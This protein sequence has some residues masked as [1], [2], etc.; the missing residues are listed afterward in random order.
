MTENIQDLPV[1]EQKSND[2]DYNFAQMRNQLAQERAAKQAAEAR[3]S[4]LERMTQNSR[5]YQEEDDDSEPYVDHKK[6]NK[7]FSSFEKEMEK[8]IDAMAEQKTRAALSQERQSNWLKQNPDF[9]E[10][11]GHAEKL[12]NSD[13]ELAETILSMPEGFE[14]QKLVYKSIKAMGFHKPPVV[15]S[16]IQDKIDANRRSPFYQPT[17]SPSGPYDS[18]GD[19]SPA[20]Q[21]SAYLK[22]KELQSKLRLG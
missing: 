7:K 22:M 6:L 9:Q 14:R 4:E 2:K 1:Q 20:G 12:A 21:K 5:N 19:F 13:P 8:K 16:S 11:M 18:Q 10:V 17:G 3:V 15:Q